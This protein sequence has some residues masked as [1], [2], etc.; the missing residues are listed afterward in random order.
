MRRSDP[1]RR[2][3]PAASVAFAGVGL[4]STE[5]VAP[6]RR[7]PS[8]SG[9][10][11][12][13]LNQR[14]A[15]RQRSELREPIKQ[16]SDQPATLSRRHRGNTERVDEIKIVLVFDQLARLAER[17]LEHA[18]PCPPGSRVTITEMRLQRLL[19]PASGPTG[20]EGV[21]HPHVRLPIAAGLVGAVDAQ[22]GESAGKPIV[23]ALGEAHLRPRLPLA[24]GAGDP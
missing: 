10:I 24:D 21:V 14:L 18:Q 16:A 19:A 4:P 6:A 20:S 2:S 23:A 8:A 17:L 12:R 3:D 11:A 13:Q 7:K 15:W 9:R 5:P 22:G 1:D